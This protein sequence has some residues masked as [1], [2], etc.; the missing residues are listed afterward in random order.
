[1]LIAGRHGM[2][3]ERARVRRN[4]MILPFI[5]LQVPRLLAFRARLSPDMVAMSTWALLPDP[6]LPRYGILLSP[7]AFFRI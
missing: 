5:A 1:M 7:A 6:C 3:Q 2:W 4:R